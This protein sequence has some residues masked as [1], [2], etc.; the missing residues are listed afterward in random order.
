VGEE[1][2]GVIVKQ[3]KEFWYDK[4]KREC[5]N[6]H[7]KMGRKLISD[8]FPEINESEAIAYARG[9]T[10]GMSASGKSKEYI[11]QRLP[12]LA[13]QDRMLD[14]GTHYFGANIIESMIVESEGRK[15]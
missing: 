8:Q 14:A 11:E 12:F 9:F 3:T 1:K 10:N 5:G 6:D 13:V 2:E 7:M 4:L 15:Q